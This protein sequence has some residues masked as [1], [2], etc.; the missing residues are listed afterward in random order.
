MN[1]KVE[2]PVRGVVTVTKITFWSG[3]DQLAP[4]DGKVTGTNVRVGLNGRISAWGVTEVPR[5]GTAF[6]DA[7]LYNSAIAGKN[8]ASVVKALVTFNKA[9]RKTSKYTGTMYLQYEDA[10][11]NVLVRVEDASPEEMEF[12][13][14]TFP[15]VES[16]AK[17]VGPKMDV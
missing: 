6:I 17:P 16:V 15:V 9:E 11:D 3:K 12:S 14:A 2:V 13:T 7:E 8:V 10:D 4:K 5:F 1:E